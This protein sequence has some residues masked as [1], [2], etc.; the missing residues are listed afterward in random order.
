MAPI[1]RPVRALSPDSH[2]ARM[3]APP[4]PTL[5]TVSSQPSRWFHS[6]S[7]RRSTMSRLA[8]V[9]AP[10]KP[11]P[12]V[13][14]NSNWNPEPSSGNSHSETAAMAAHAAARAR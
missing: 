5:S 6:G 9:T 4:W 2:A 11:A 10:A 1:S 14:A 7:G 8:I 13:S 12:S 3:S